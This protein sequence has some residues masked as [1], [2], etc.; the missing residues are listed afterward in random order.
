MCTLVEYTHK[1]VIDISV[2]ISVA[3]FFGIAAHSSSFFF[4]ESF[5]FFFRIKKT[6][7]KL[8]LLMLKLLSCCLF[9]FTSTNFTTTEWNIDE[10][11]VNNRT[12]TACEKNKADRFFSLDFFHLSCFYGFCMFLSAGKKEKLCRIWK[13]WMDYEFIF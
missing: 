7:K 5:S 9:P 12:W 6:K 4:A 8:S 11:H 3:S 13:S 10:I 2:S 1:K